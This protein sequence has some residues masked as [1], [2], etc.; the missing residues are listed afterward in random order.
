MLS[1]LR[2]MPIPL[3][4]SARIPRT[5][6]GLSVF[7]FPGRQQLPS[8]CDL[9]PLK[10][11]PSPPRKLPTPSSFV[12]KGF[13]EPSCSRTKPAPPAPGSYKIQGR[14]H[15]GESFEIF[16]PYAFPVVLSEFDLYLM[17]EGRHF[18]TYEKLGAHVK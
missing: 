18:D 13:F 6:T 2:A 11:P 3:L 8:L 15:T 12:P 14:T 17:G 5:A 16:D 9:P 10:A 1:S 7:S 4:S